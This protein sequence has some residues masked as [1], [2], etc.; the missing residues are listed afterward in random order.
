MGTIA[1][2]RSC[3]AAPLDLVGMVLQLR[4]A[5]GKCPLAHWST[6]CVSGRVTPR[7]AVPRHVARSLG[8]APQPCSRTSPSVERSAWPQS[9][10]LTEIRLLVS[11]E[12]VF[13]LIAIASSTLF[14]SGTRTAST[15]IAE[16]SREDATS[17][18]V[19]TLMVSRF[20]PGAQGACADAAMA[21]MGCDGSDVW[22]SAAAAAIAP[23][24]EGV[25]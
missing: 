3:Y 7:C 6:V 13:A 8:S 19:M 24:V 10:S 17:P 4:R 14:P 2:A 25:G 22:A 5:V 15:A 11:S 23:G 21:V 9:A 16:P 1:A 18:L 20:R 12:F